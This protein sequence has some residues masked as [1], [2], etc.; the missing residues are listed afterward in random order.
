M[1]TGRD[2]L[3]TN[4][5]IEQIK[6]KNWYSSNSDTSSYT[7]TDEDKYKTFFYTTGASDVTLTLPAVADNV[8]RE[9]RAIKVDAGAGDVVISG[10]V[11]GTTTQTINGNV[12]TS[13]KGQYG[14][15]ALKCNSTEWF[16]LY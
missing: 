16:K 7:I 1:K 6:R 14:V 13:V 4:H 15:M 8:N 3:D 11:V 2:N 12:T 10:K 5:F 9:I